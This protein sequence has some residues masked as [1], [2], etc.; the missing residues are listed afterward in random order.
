MK[1]IFLSLAVVVSFSIQAF[2]QHKPHKVYEVNVPIDLSIAVISSGLTGY[3]FYKIEQKEGS[4]LAE[5]NAL[6]WEEDVPG[7]NRFFG[8]PNYSE[9][10]SKTSD[11]LFYGAMPLGIGLALDKNIRK[12]IWTVLLMYWETLGITGTIYGNTAA[13][14]VKY[15]PLAYPDPD[16]GVPV[17]PEEARLEDGAKNSFPG[18][19]PTITA[20]STFFIAKV[21]HDYYPER[22]TM[23]F[24]AFSTASVLTLTNVYLRHRA[25]KHFATDLMVGLAYSVPL[26][27]LIPELHRITEE[28][29][30]LSLFNGRNG[31]TLSYKLE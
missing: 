2:S 3:G 4:T 26:G 6:N 5:V 16:T 17:A 29:E 18:G 1:N 7:F 11:L 14:V 15:R 22:K 31:L 8:G 21:L 9:S 30:R 13:N 28:N 23:H 20:A 25:G 10:A 19:H 27:I 12:D 24:I